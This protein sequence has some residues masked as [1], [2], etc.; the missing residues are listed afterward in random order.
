MVIVISSAS[1]GDNQI[2]D[3]D[4]GTLMHPEFFGCLV[5]AYSLVYQTLRSV[6]K[7]FHCS[8]RLVFVHIHLPILPTCLGVVS[9]SVYKTTL[10]ASI[11]S[12]HLAVE[13]KDRVKNI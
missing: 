9:E 11:L 4:N 6:K 7:S 5:H 8:A 13:N 1:D 12:R 10:V 3:S 2:K